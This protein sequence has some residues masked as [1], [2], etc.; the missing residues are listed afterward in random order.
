MSKLIDV[1]HCFINDAV[2]DVKHFLKKP[3]H[4]T[5]FKNTFLLADCKQL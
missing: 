5:P 2:F 4:V 3:V 1:P